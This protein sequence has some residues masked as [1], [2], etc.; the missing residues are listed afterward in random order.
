MKVTIFDTP[1]RDGKLAL[2]QKRTVPQKLP[3]A[4]IL[5]EAGVDK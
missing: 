5:D 3:I 4:G 1:L 2:K